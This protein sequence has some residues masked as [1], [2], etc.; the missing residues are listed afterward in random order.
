MVD[1]AFLLAFAVILWR[2]LSVAVPQ[3]ATRD[4]AW[5]LLLLA[6]AIPYLVP[7]YPAWF[8]PLLVVAVDGKL[9]RIGLAAGCLLALTG[10]PSD[11]SAL[12]ELETASGP[13]VLVTN[14]GLDDVFVFTFGPF[15]H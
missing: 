1:A 3:A 13:E 14:D 8:L 12:E 10:I 15:P 2:I 5:A 9:L 7:W 11:P 4:W 6:L